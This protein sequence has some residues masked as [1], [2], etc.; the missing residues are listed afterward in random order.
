MAPYQVKSCP[1]PN[2]R[3]R[4][5]CVSK[6]CAS[7]PPS[8]NCSVSISTSKRRKRVVDNIDKE[9]ST[10]KC[11]SVVNELFNLFRVLEVKILVNPCYIN[12]I[13]KNITA[14]HRLQLVNWLVEIHYRYNLVTETIYLSVQ[15]IDRFLERRPVRRT[16]LQKLAMAAISIASRYEDVHAPK[17]LSEEFSLYYNIYRKSEI[18]DMENELLIALNYNLSYPTIFSFLCR[19]CQA[20]H[21]DRPIGR[22]A[23]FISERTLHEYSMLKHLPSVIAASAILI[24]RSSL[25]RNPWSVTLE[26]YTQYEVEDLSACIGD[27]KTFLEKKPSKF[28]NT[29]RKFGSSTFGRITSTPLKYL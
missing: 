13:Q 28:C 21:A 23:L 10:E 1:N 15:L 26:H 25:G 27:M 17:L 9:G 8:I 5:E 22:L 2:K 29:F 24:A 18:I 6:F 11:C 12:T 3:N 7:C 20:G 4:E 14:E 19:Y 16:N